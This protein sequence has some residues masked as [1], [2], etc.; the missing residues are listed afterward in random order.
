MSSNPDVSVIITNYNYEKYISRAVR[1]CLNQ[2]GVNHEVIVVDDC[3]TDN[4]IETLKPFKDQIKIVSTG[5]N[6]GVAVAANVGVKK[7]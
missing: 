7:Q 5:A 2:F 3:S 1:S 4:S 6:G